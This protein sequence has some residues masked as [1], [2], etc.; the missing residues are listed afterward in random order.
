MERSMFENRF[1]HAP[2]TR[3]EQLSAPFWGKEKRTRPW[4]QVNLFLWPFWKPFWGHFLGR[5]C[6]N[7]L[8]SSIVM[9]PT[10]IFQTPI[11]DFKLQCREISRESQVKF[12]IKKN[13]LWTRS[14]FLIKTFYE[15]DRWN[16]LMRLKELIA[17]AT[18]ATLS[19]VNISF[20]ILRSTPQKNNSKVH[21]S[22]KF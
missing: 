6:C 1:Y 3:T 7:D 18:L 5:P 11:T 2:F 17:E 10:I 15:H 19:N 12:L 21:S 9:I 20:Q 14:K 22:K 4:L 8:I 13:F 16:K